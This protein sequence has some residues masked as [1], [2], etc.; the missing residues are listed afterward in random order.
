MKLQ[1]RT[2]DEYSFRSHGDGDGIGDVAEDRAVQ[3]LRLHESP[4]NR[5]TLTNLRP[6]SLA[7]VSQLSNS[8]SY[9]DQNQSPDE[10]AKHGLPVGTADGIEQ[11][12]V[13]WQGQQSC[14]NTCPHAKRPSRQEN[15]Q[16]D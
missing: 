10:T 7:K 8:S 6:K 13:H 15:R 4:L 3:L 5:R 2:I 11:Y 16:S 1:E 14:G 9:E 12:H